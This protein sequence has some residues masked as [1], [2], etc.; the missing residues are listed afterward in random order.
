MHSG[1]DILLGSTGS[2]QR[3]DSVDRNAGQTPPWVIET[4][5]EAIPPQPLRL[6]PCAVPSTVKAKTRGLS[7]SPTSAPVPIKSVPRPVARKQLSAPTSSAHPHLINPPKE[8]R[9]AKATTNPFANGLTNLESIETN[10]FSSMVV[11]ECNFENER[12][13]QSA[14]ISKNPFIQS[15]MSSE[16]NV[17]DFN[18]TT[19]RSVLEE[20]KEDDGYQGD[21]EEKVES[22]SPSRFEKRVKK[23][24]TASKPGRESET[25]SPNKFS[26][27]I[28]QESPAFEGDAIM[29]FET[30]FCDKAELDESSFNGESMMKIYQKHPRNRSFSENRESDISAMTASCENVD[31]MGLFPQ[32]TANPFKNGKRLLKTPSETYL[33]TFSMMRAYQTSNSANNKSSLLKPSSNQN[34]QNSELLFDASTKNSSSIKRVASS[35][36]ISSDS[37]VVFNKLVRTAPPVTGT[38]GISLQFDK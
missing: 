4:R 30:N 24:E 1:S 38:L 12:V 17:F 25:S 26:H 27:K 9:A 7:N 32:S 23:L 18:P 13:S 34:V 14:F 37:S 8:V 31:P 20:T 6:A 22:D 10:A 11:N 16:L 2:F 29:K 19:I 36:S 21:S 15:S 5:N 28:L 3:F 33:E 35:E